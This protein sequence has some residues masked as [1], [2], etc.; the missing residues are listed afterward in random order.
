[1]VR[2]EKQATT[3]QNS[4]VSTTCIHV[5]YTKI[6]LGSAN[7]RCSCMWVHT[8]VICGSCCCYCWLELLL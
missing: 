1:L 8:Y 2:F 4:N 5:R 7:D 6:V 3:N